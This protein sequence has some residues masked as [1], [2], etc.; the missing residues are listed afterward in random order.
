MGENDEFTSVDQLES[1]VARM[2]AVDPNCRV[3]IDIVKQVTHFQLE[4]QSYDPI[5]AAKVVQWLQNVL[6]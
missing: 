2:K 1:M 6:Q 3:D 5:V 4:S